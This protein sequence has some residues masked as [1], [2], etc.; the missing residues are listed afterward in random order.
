MARKY[1]VWWTTYS[2]DPDT[3]ESFFVSDQTVEESEKDFNWRKNLPLGDKV[4][5]LNQERIRPRVA[6]FPVSALYDEETQRN[7]AKML[8]DYMNKINDAMEQ[9]KAQ[10]ALIDLISAQAPT[11]FSN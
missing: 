6:T 9:A 4:K 10:T 1:I 3:I 2:D 11:N 8:C 7:R 5:Y